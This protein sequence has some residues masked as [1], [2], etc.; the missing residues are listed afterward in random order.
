MVDNYD[1]IDLV[2]MNEKLQVSLKNVKNSYVVLGKALES[3]KSIFGNLREAREKTEDVSTLVHNFMIRHQDSEEK[4]RKTI[5]LASI[6]V[7]LL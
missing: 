4:S 3:A 5:E 7:L 2:L 1:D 6:Q